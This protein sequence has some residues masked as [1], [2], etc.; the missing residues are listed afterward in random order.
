MD[1]NNMIEKIRDL[2]KIGEKGTT[3]FESAFKGER[4][5]EDEF[6]AWFKSEDRLWL[7]NIVYLLIALSILNLLDFF[8]E[9]ALQHFEIAKWIQRL[10]IRQIVYWSE[11]VVIIIVAL[12]IVLKSQ[13]DTPSEP[14]PVRAASNAA[15]RLLSFWPLL[16]LSWFTLY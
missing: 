3:F 8:S 12:D 5:A 6:R 9:A 2:L 15:R 7:R 4:N 10:D 1:D 13:F 11:M 16:W 14:G